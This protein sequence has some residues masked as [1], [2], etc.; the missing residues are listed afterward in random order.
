[1]KHH[2]TK[3]I[4]LYDLFSNE[5][6]ATIEYVK[7]A[8]DGDNSGHLKLHEALLDMYNDFPNQL[9]QRLVYLDMASGTGTSTIESQCNNIKEN[10]DE[11]Q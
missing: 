11:G 1:M 5:I 4:A 2:D 9:E 10:T 6:N 7:D 3:T 8:K